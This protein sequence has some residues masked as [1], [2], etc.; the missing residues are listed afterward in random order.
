MSAFCPR[1]V[2]GKLC[3][4]RR[5]VGSGG[6]GGTISFTASYRRQVIYR[7]RRA[8]LWN[9]L[10]QDTVV[11]LL[12]SRRGDHATRRRRV[13]REVGPVSPHRVEDA[14]QLPRQRDDRDS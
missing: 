1:S 12:L 14:G 11:I 9:L 5:I 10:S 6:K 2:V 13:R 8:V 3:F 7:A 4:A